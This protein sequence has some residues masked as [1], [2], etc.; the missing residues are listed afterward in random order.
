VYPG[1]AQER[2]VEGVVVIQAIL[3]PGGCVAEAKVRQSIPLLDFAALQAVSYWR[4]TPVLLDGK[5]VPVIMMITVK[6]AL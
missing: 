4:Y 5:P 2:R 6:F 1:V 3:S